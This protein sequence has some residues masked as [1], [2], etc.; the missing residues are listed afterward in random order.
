MELRESECASHRIHREN[1]DD[2]DDRKDE[3]NGIDGTNGKFLIKRSTPIYPIKRS[4]PI[5]PIKRAERVLKCQKGYFFCP[6][7]PLSR[8]I[9]LLSEGVRLGLSQKKI[10]SG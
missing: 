5:Y 6:F 1:R 2:R 9:N 10:P 8:E 4:G 3:I 7:R